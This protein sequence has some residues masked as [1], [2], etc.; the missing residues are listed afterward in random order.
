MTDPVTNPAANPGWAQAATPF[1]AGELAIQARLGVQDRLDRQGRR[2]I[3]DYLTERHRQFFA[4]LSYVL[5]G[6]VDGEGRPW[7]SIL[8]GEPG[9]ITAPTDGVDSPEVHRTLRIE[10]QPLH[11]DPLH[12]TLA[13]GADIGLLGIE[14]HSRRRNRINGRVTALGAGGF[15]VG[16]SQSFGN[17]PQYIQARRF[18]LRAVDA[19]APKPV[20]ALTALGDR[21]REMTAAADTSFIATAYQDA[22]AGAASGV[23]V[24]HRGGQ[25]GLVRLDDPQTLTIPDF[26]GNLHFNTCGNLAL[27]PRAGLLFLDFDRGDLLYLTG[28]AEVIW[29]GDAVAAYPGA[30][31]LLHVHLEQGDRV[32]GS[33]PLSWSAPE[34]S[35]LLASTGPWADQANGGSLTIRDL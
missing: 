12:R 24:S 20:Y 21:D 8:V 23:D 31:R 27:N 15:T 34:F 18:D 2:V 35:P 19:I 4:Q 3:R 32:E 11:G 13:T 22:A 7:A 14:L 1:H 28:T 17:C 26:S 6:M 30:K 10:A 5:V 33:L 9:F 25:P 16:V 29:S